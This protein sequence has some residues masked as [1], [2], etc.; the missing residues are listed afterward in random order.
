MSDGVPAGPGSVLVEACVD[1][2]E[3]AL[4]AEAGGG[5]GVELC[6]DLLEGGTTPSAG[7]IELCCERAGIPVF[8]MIRPRGG[9]FLYSDA[10]FEV[11]RRDIAR[12]A[13]L[14]AAGIVLGLLRPD[15]S[16]DAARTRLLVEEAR[17]LP[18]TFHRA[19]D[20][21][22]D[23]DEAFDTLLALGVNRVLTS[24]RAATAEEGVDVIAGMVRRAAGRIA[25]LAG[26][27]IREEN[28]ARVVADT[29]VREVHVR[30]TVVRPG[31]M[32]Y[33]NPTIDF[34]GRT[35]PPDSLLEVTDPARIQRLVRLAQEAVAPP[36]GPR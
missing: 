29:G 35:A 8:V 7:M 3:S 18:V 26:G 27:G 22:R 34:G 28:L 5:G 33:R 11:M 25:V 21:S 23:M 30:G 13:A 1:S 10:E 19:I 15:G 20:V 24:G 12:A 6:D 32:A 2:V 9:D 4:A 14:G 17:P 36:E 31:G 16:V